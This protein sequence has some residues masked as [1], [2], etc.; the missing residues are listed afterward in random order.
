M[1][2]YVALL[3]GINVGG[4]NKIEMK[5]LKVSFEKL[6]FK[7]VVTYI[8]SGNIVFDTQ[9]TN[10]HSLITRIE[11]AISKEF[12]LSIPVLLRSQQEIDDLIKKIPETWRNDSE[13]KTDIWFLWDEYRSKDTLKLLKINK[14]VDNV[15]Y[16]DGVVVWRVKKADFSKSKMNEVI[17]TDIYKNIT[18]RNINTL[19]KIKEIMSA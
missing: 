18:V 10:E 8:N 4:K 1:T 7:N 2:R 15:S 5:M 12:K 19:R 6:G 3:R 17:K 11:K 16:H 9:I 14:T 13:Y